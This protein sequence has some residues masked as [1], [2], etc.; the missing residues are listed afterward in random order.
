MC[1]LQRKHE[2]GGAFN[3]EDDEEGLTHYGRSLGDMERFDEIEVSDE[4]ETV[5]GV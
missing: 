4:E 1:F 3:L 5:E 2:R